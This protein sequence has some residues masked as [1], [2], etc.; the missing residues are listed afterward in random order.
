[1]TEPRFFS[2][3]YISRI[4][5]LIML[6]ALIFGQPMSGTLSA[7]ESDY[8]RQAQ[9]LL[10]SMTPEERVGQLFLVTFE[11]GSAEVDSDI[12]DLIVDYKVGGVMLRAANDN[13]NDPESPAV[14]AAGNRQ[15]V[16]ISSKVRSFLLAPQARSL[17]P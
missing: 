17:S 1:L 10:D 7:Q 16:V 6:L 9:S 5:L 2:N 4:V 8:A 3:E 11:G 14:G 12:A 15:T 13:F